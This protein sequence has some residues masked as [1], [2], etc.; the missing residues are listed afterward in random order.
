MS[1]KK[2]KLSDEIEEE[3]VGYETLILLTQTNTFL[4]L[5]RM[6]TEI[7]DLIKKGD[8][9][10]QIFNRLKNKYDIAPNLLKSDINN[11]IK[12]LEDKKVISFHSQP[13][14]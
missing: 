11:Y 5:N 10:I 12:S 1:Y 13:I 6:G 4:K 7:W 8:D 2:I 14:K 3:R 9:E